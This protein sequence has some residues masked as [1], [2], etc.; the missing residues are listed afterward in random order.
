M[1]N[2]APGEMGRVLFVC[3]SRPEGVIFWTPL[4]CALRK[5]WPICHITWV[6][7]EDECE[8]LLD[9]QAADRVVV[10]PG[11]RWRPRGWISRVRAHAYVHEAL[12][13]GRFDF[14][15]SLWPS[16]DARVICSYA[17][18]EKTRYFN[19]KTTLAAWFPL[20]G[21]V[22]G[23]YRLAAGEAGLTIDEV[24]YGFELSHSGRKGAQRLVER[25]DAARRSYAVLAPFDDPGGRGWPA[26]N[27]VKIG[28][29]LMKRGV[30]GILIA[31]E[32]RDYE[33]ARV[34]ARRIGDGARPIAGEAGWLVMRELLRQSV[35]VVGGPGRTVFLARAVG[36]PAVMIDSVQRPASYAAPGVHILAP[37]RGKPV[38]VERVLGGALTLLFENA[39]AAREGKAATPGIQRLHPKSPPAT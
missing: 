17:R 8:L 9:N 6:T 25:I 14:V 27:Y 1:N 30:E 29:A 36:T 32:D 24:N 4:A 3:L 10:F 20:P 19:P 12:L 7:D 23:P 5:Q 22:P 21:S 33:K 35:V 13:W 18:S 28:G 26:D 15:A 2:G 34:L 16:V 11:R 37:N 38:T 31:G 39:P